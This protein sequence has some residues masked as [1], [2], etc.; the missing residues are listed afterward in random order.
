MGRRG[1]KRHTAKGGQHQR[2]HTHSGLSRGQ[3]A[4]ADRRLLSNTAL[5]C[6]V[7]GFGT[8]ARVPFAQGSRT[9]VESD[10]EGVILQ[11]CVA[12]RA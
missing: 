6:S 12:A 4:P 3:A 2:A 9:L 5:V 8:A 7:E 1:R 11:V 10:A